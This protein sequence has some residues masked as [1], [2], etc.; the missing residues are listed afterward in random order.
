MSDNR[1]R[2]AERVKL[3]RERKGWSVAETA[4]RAQLSSSMLWKVENGQTSLT[5]EKLAALAAGLEVEIGELFAVDSEPV[6]T[7][8]RRVID[9]G[10]APMVDLNGNL[11]FFLATDIADKQLLPIL[12]EVRATDPVQHELEAHGGEEF[13]YV[14]EGV[15]DFHCEGYAPARL[16]AGDS[17]YFDACLRHCYVCG[18]GDIARIICTYSNPQSL[19]RPAPMPG[20]PL[21]PTAMRLL[22]QA[23]ARKSDE[24]AVHRRAKK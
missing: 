13:T 4:R 18:E 10:K 11:H 23:T 1:N 21:Q 15:V 16:R 20:I 8:G 7:G 19:A 5:Y 2:L 14:L 22:S 3:L 17:V 12:V 9:R 24:P 6:R